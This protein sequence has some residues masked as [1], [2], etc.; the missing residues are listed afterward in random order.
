MVCFLLRKKMYTP[1][2]KLNGPS[3]INLTKNCGDRL[4]KPILFL[5]NS[6]IKAL[7]FDKSIF[8]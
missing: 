3:L 1:K 4:Y 8:K 6:E 5:A 7:T 2:T